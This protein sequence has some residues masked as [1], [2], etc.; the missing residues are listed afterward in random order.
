MGVDAIS[1][2]EDAKESNS[3]KNIYAVSTYDANNPS[4]DNL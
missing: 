1:L 4:S 3:E 2:E